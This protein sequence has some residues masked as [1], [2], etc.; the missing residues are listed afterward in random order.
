MNGARNSSR[1]RPSVNMEGRIVSMEGMVGRVV[2]IMAAKY[3]YAL[4]IWQIPF[5]LLM[6]PK[7]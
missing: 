2:Y 3:C 4:K 5:V 1:L 7:T 6:L